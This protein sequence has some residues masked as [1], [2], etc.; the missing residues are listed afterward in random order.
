MRTPLRFLLA[1]VLLIA[2]VAA[3]S[4]AL[5]A[6]GKRSQRVTA[7]SARAA[8]PRPPARPAKAGVPVAGRD[9]VRGRLLVG[10]RAGTGS[11]TRGA[12]LRAVGARTGRALGRSQLALVPS[13]ADVPAVAGR[14]AAQPGVA[15]AEPDWIRHVNACDPSVCWYL[16]S[17][18]VTPAWPRSTS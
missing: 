10:F 11:A 17:A 12:A 3:G 9:F 4:V 6:P 18:G 2:L 5:A 8:R 7:A 13:G 14:L 15:F 16:D 1:A